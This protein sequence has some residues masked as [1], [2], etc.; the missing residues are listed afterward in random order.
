MKIEKNNKLSDAF[1]GALKQEKNA[2]FTI[3]GIPFDEKTTYRRGTSGGPD[4]IREAST[5]QSINSFTASGVDLKDDLSIYDAGNL[6]KKSNTEEYFSKISGFIAETASR[7]S[8]PV[9]LGGDHSITFP[10]VRGMLE[11]YGSLHIVWLDSHPD[12]YEDYEGDRLSHACPLAR[13]LE[14]DGVNRVVQ[15]GIRAST[16]ELNRRLQ[17]AGVKVFSV[18]DLATMK[19]LE[20]LGKTYL[21]I[22]ID[23]LDPAFAP[24]VGTPVPGGIS[25]RELLDLILSFNLDIVGFDLVE[26]NPDYDHASITAAAGAKV[27]METI[28]RIADLRKSNFTYSSE[29]Y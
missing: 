15:G 19:H 8:V 14:L 22:D 18:S 28:G 7:G 11:T 2:D 13:I 3:V 9:T 25:T 27:V 20:M 5:V 21:S 1:G 10:V 12:I 26:T 23:V 6:M 29:D 4:A 16:R 24:G 17:E